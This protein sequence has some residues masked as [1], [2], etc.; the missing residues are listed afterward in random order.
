[1]D[2]NYRKTA[3]NRLISDWTDLICELSNQSHSIAIGVF[4]SEAQL[5]EANQAMCF[6]LDTDCS[7]L[8]PK[9]SFINP[10]FSCFLTD[11]NKEL[12]FD[13]LMTIGNYSDISYVVN[14]KVFRKNDRIM[15]YAETDILN[16]FEEN[17][18]MSVLNQEVNNLQ[19]QLIKEKKNLQATLAE[20][21]ETQQMLIHSEKM[22]A[23]GKLVAGVAHE[24]NNPI[25]FVYSN[26]FSL[27][28]YNAEVFDTIK[29]IERLIDQTGNQELIVSMSNL[30]KSNDLEYLKEDLT[31]LTKESKVGVER[32]RTIVEDLRRFSRLDESDLKQVDLIENIRSTISIVKAEISK[33]S[34]DFKFVSP[35]HLLVNCF[36]GQLNQA[37]LNVLVNAIQAVEESGQVI[38]T[39]SV[40]KNTVI[41]EIKDNGDGIPDEIKTRI[42]EPFFTTKPVGSGTGLGLSITYK[43]I[44]DLHQGAIELDSTLHKGTKMKLLIPKKI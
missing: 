36:P 17:K 2:I 19:R 41:I 35:D 39:V 13:G 21:K 9:N 1:M 24:L 20:L 23:M 37:I 29:Q 34:I 3:E 25:A 18:K 43:I 8:Q 27:E 4:D 28:K 10:E 11:K 42:F 6:F 33:K 44:H 31:D 32:V 40:E 14:A 15:V 12:V 22:N 16:L 5:L 26:L 38:V 30:M 7:K